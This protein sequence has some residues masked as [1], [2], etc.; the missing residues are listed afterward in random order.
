[1]RVDIL[2]GMIHQRCLHIV[3]YDVG[4][5]FVICR[6]EYCAINQLKPRGT[7]ARLFIAQSTV[8]QIKI[9]LLNRA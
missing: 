2:H 4:G 1:M 9:A 3:R 7:W 5:Q 8:R 6:S